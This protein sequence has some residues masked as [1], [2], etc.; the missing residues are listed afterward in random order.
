MENK[1]WFEKLGWLKEDYR[2]DLSGF[3][4]NQRLKQSVFHCNSF[5]FHLKKTAIFKIL[6]THIILWNV[7]IFTY[8]N[9]FY[10]FCLGVQ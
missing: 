10:L 2:F 9:D 5:S 7:S 8:D 4:T 3:L 6:S 1:T